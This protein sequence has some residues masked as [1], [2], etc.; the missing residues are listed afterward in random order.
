MTAEF[1]QNA[2]SLFLSIIEYVAPI[3]LVI[4]L[5]MKL[6]RIGVRAICGRF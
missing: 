2:S 5:S 4:A 6:V 3:S 1:L